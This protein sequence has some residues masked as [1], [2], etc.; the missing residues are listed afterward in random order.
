MAETQ[1]PLDQLRVIGSP[2][3]F[4]VYDNARRKLSI[5]ALDVFIRQGHPPLM[6][7]AMPAGNI[8]V[9]GKTLFAIADPQTGKPRVVKRIEWADGESTEFPDPEKVQAV[10]NSNANGQGQAAGASAIPEQDNVK[11]DPVHP[12]GDA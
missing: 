12:M 8:D 4:A 1:G 11:D 6:Q 3:G 9:V 10:F 5:M 7:I 2:Q